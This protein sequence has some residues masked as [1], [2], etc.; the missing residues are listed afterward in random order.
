MGM[1][2]RT[3]RARRERRGWWNRIGAHSPVQRVIVV[4]VPAF[5]AGAL[6]VINAIG[7][8]QSPPSLNSTLVAGLLLTPSATSMGTLTWRARDARMRLFVALLL[9]AL[10]LSCLLSYVAA[11]VGVLMTGAA[12]LLILDPN[13]L[14]TVSA[15]CGLAVLAHSG[16]LRVW[17]ALGRTG[18]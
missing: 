15:V 2:A 11:L 17:R 12:A 6:L 9:A 10:V 5:L 4:M 13:L 1:R 14:D 3:A 16:G 7:Y 18:L 8:R